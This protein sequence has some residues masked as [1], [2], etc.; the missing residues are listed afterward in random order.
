MFSDCLSDLRANVSYV[1][2]AMTLCFQSVHELHKTKALL[3]CFRKER[4][5]IPQLV[6]RC[7]LHFLGHN[8]LHA[9]LLGLIQWAWDNHNSSQSWA[10]SYPNWKQHL[11]F[12]NLL[13]EHRRGLK[14]SLL[15]TTTPKTMYSSHRFLSS[16]FVSLDSMSESFQV[17][18]PTRD[19]IWLPEK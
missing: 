2:V 11:L 6:S 1:L 12:R 18:R 10:Q 9:W 16:K 5:P 14:N 15:K 17:N 19:K 13:N 8:R 7:T 3:I 4:D